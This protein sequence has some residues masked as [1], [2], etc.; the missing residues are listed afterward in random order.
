MNAE[1]PLGE[2]ADASES[3]SLTRLGDAMGARIS[4]ED[5]SW[6]WPRRS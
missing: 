4:Q 1:M 3:A 2:A 6:S 5:R